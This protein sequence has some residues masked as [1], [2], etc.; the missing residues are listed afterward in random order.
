[1]TGS[2]NLNPIEAMVLVRFLTAGAKGLKTADL[3]KDLAP[4]LEHRWS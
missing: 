4:L 1:M 3:R 2:Q